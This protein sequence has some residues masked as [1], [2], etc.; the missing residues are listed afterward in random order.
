MY[1]HVL[2]GSYTCIFR[3]H[4]Q[5]NDNVSITLLQQVSLYFKLVNDNMST[6]VSIVCYFLFYD[7]GVYSLSSVISPTRPCSIFQ[8]PDWNC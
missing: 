7:R 4:K 2:K 3:K 5:V 6:C 1:M 8:L